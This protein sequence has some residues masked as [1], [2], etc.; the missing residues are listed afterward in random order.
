[1]G[2]WRLETPGGVRFGH[3][4]WVDIVVTNATNALSDGSE[5]AAPQSASS[6]DEAV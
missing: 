1:M 6:D 4:L 3:R 2:Y 5:D